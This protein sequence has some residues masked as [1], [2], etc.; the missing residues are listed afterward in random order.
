MKI[1]NKEINNF[2]NTN[3]RT[4]NGVKKTDGII[5]LK[6]K[7]FNIERETELFIIDNEN[8]NHDSHFF[9]FTGK[10]YIKFV[11]Y[12]DFIYIIVGMRKTGL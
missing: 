1:K 10:L 4:I 6:I 7:I 9:C 2:T 3:L 12:V 5:T 8:F 11:K